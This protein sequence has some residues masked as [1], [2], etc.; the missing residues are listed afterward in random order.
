MNKVVPMGS[1]LE[2]FHGKDLRCINLNGVAGY[3]AFLRLWSILISLLFR[4]ILVDLRCDDRM[5]LILSRLHVALS[6]LVIRLPKTQSVQVELADL[7]LSTSC[8]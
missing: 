1:S 6:F 3:I 4:R 2:M 8:T 7:Y 5:V